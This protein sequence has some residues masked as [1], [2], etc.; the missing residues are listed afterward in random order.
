MKKR[1]KLED[2]KS[3][4]VWHVTP[5]SLEQET[6]RLDESVTSS[7]KEGQPNYVTSYF[8]AVSKRNVGTTLMHVLWRPEVVRG[9][10]ST[11]C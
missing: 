4:V 8:L 3:N 6:G 5:G 2:A 9:K 10:I 11:F 7:F 1:P